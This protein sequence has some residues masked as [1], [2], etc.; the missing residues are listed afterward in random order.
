M[1]DRI[2]R[3]NAALEGRYRIE[4]E[5]GQGGMATV[6]L[7]DDLRHGRSVAIKVLK[8]EVAAVIGADRFLAEIRTTANLQHPHI[9]PLHDSGEADGFL[10]Y[11]MP[12]VEG[13][14]LRDRLNRERQLPVSQ[15]VTIATKVATALQ[16][17]HDQG[18][19]HRDV[20]PANILLSK[21]EPLVADF[22]IAL[23]VGA[24]SRLTATGLAIG[25]VVYMSPEQAAGDGPIDGR[26]DIYS[27]GCVLYEMLAGETPFGRGSVQVILARKLAGMVPDLGDPPGTAPQTVGDVIRK[28]LAADP[29]NR[30]GTAAQFSEALSRAVTDDAI[31][32]RAGK[33]RWRLRMRRAGLA[34]SLALVA[35]LGWWGWGKATGP[36]I[37]RLSV[38]TPVSLT[39]APDQ[40]P[41]AQGIHNALINEL[42]Q[43]GVSV[44][45][46]VQSMMRYRNRDMSIREIA[47][48]L[49]VDAMIES[50][51]FWAGDSVGIDVRLL[52]A[53][54]EESLW[55][56]SYGEEASNVLT[57]YRT[58]TA[59][60]AGEIRLALTP[61]AEARLTQAR[62]V[63][64]QAHEAYLRAQFHWNRLTPQD[65]ATALEYLTVALEEDPDYAEA[66]AGVA[67]VRVA[68][69][70]LG[71]LPPGEA[72]PLARAAAAS[73]MRLDSAS[74]EAQYASASVGW[75]TW[76][77]AA[78]E[79]GYSRALE[80]N[81]NLALVRGDYSHFL[82]V[83]L[84][85]D[86]AMAQID[87]A[88]EI[89]PFNVQLMAFRGMV[90]LFQRRYQDALDQ[91]EQ[92]LTMVPNM[93]VALNGLWHANHQ[94]GREEE[95]LSAA[96]FVAEATGVA[97]AAQVLRSA[98]A[99]VGYAG[100]F[101]R[102]ADV[103]AGAANER[104]VAPM[105][106]AS[107]YMSADRFDD[108]MVW[109]ER[110]V[111]LKEPNSPYISVIPELDPLRGD[112]RFQRLLRR[113]GLPAA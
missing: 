9:L 112:P 101:A 62:T 87:R 97:E 85:P 3:L 88:V 35:G 45:G 25:T 65:F 19:I 52:D 70:Q 41:L 82:S 20:K 16:A 59:A 53:D 103:L 21:G 46:G 73:A 48:E 61:D 71:I 42:S 58:V 98:Y 90:L 11:V 108:A 4:R 69:Q 110:G 8:R 51:F 105:T 84:R 28:A 86:E 83:M 55:S 39:N 47:R 107:F 30:Y 66:Q 68:Q 38:L 56:G 94:L 13:D 34:A 104:F 50:A 77:W 91:M 106:V 12:Y 64:P 75:A 111:D 7:A 113:V 33:I 36:A 49:G 44:I 2:L 17:A 99:D 15:A 60:I 26:S 18:V 109:L 40:E 29:A 1:S 80:L 76:D 6:Y 24:A 37:E 92:V 93:G 43:A 78:A 79:A 74:P 14:S 23:A 10:Y 32:Q 81:P 102:A 72:T 54:T 5:I 22:G 100:A 63:D 27:L 57:L 31:A 67:W 96:E 95:A 89:D